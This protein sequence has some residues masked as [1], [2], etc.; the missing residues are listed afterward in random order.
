[1][2]Q[3]APYLVADSVASYST[4]HID[5]ESVL[6]VF[7]PHEIAEGLAFRQSIPPELM[8]LCA[9]GHSGSARSTPSSGR[10]GT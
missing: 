9:D 4:D 1:M 10:S 7:E 2:V 8:A 5:E 6:A 3:V